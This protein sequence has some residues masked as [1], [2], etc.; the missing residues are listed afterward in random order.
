MTTEPYG[1]ALIVEEIRKLLDM[2]F[3]RLNELHGLGGVPD[4]LAEEVRGVAL[5]A[6]SAT[7]ENFLKCHKEADRS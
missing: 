4:E 1:P 7:R 3:W 6:K 2:T 5:W